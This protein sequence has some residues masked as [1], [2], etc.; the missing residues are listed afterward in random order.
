MKIDVNENQVIRLSEIYVPIHCVADNAQ[1]VI[2]Q[3]DGVFEIGINDDS[4][5]NLKGEQHLQYYN[6]YRAENNEIKIMLPKE[7]KEEID[8]NFT[9][10]QLVENLTK[11]EK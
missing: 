10:E 6:W 2:C 5:K 9:K 11:K 7:S 4:I 8:T 1:I 3:R